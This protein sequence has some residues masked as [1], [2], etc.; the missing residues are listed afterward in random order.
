MKAFNP[1]SIKNN[2]MFMISRIVLSELVDLTA[3]LHAKKVPRPLRYIICGSCAIVICFKNMYV[4]GRI[5]TGKGVV[6]D[7]VEMPITTKCTLKCKACSNLMPY[8]SKPYNIDLKTNIKHIKDFIE[9]VDYIG[10]FLILG[11][12]PFVNP[13]FSD[14]VTFLIG[15]RKVK[16]IILITNGTICPNDEIME[17][18]SNPK[19]IVEISDYGSLS[20]NKDLLI[21]SLKRHKITISQRR[22]QTEEDVV[23]H[24]WGPPKSRGASIEELKKQYKLCGLRCSSYLNGELHHCP[25]SAHLHDLGFIEDCSN[26]FIDVEKSK[27]KRMDI[28][29]FYYNEKDYIKACDMCFMGTQYARDIPAG[30]QMK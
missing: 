27:N 22:Y 9:G 15:Q 8:Y 25:R 10:K 2:K 12:E 29:N 4:I 30:E 28:Y 13:I 11:G 21:E 16:H 18:I 6:I 14:I 19:V 26:D 24:D 7:Q 17:K 3:W 5:I 20:R 1:H 23:W